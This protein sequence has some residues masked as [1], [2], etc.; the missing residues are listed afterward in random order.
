NQTPSGLI[1]DR[2]SNH[3]PPRPAGQCSTAATGM[4]WIALALA[5]APPYRLLGR[6]EAVLRVRTGL[7]TALHRLPPDGG[8]GPHF[9]HAETGSVSGHDAFS[10]VDSAWLVAG[11]LWAAAFLG[12]ARLERLAD[13]LY[14]RVDWAAWSGG[15]DSPLLHHGR[16]RDGRLLPC[17]WD[18]IN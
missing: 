15:P 14:G 11:A 5:A 13:E 8:V 10:T 18:R 1:L 2:Q 3:G 9:V 12:D 4:G 17:T 6:A 7:E 16:G